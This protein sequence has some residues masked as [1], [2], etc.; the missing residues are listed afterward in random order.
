MHSSLKDFLSTKMTFIFLL[1]FISNTNFG[2]SRVLFEKSNGLVNCQKIRT[3]R[4][5]TKLNQTIENKGK[6]K[7]EKIT[8]L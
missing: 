1:N 7:A 5:L 3:K 4:N 8:V 2:S 6:P